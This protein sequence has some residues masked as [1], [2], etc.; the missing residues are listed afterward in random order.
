[1]Q[2][3]STLS[4]GT[5]ARK[6]PGK[7]DLSISHVQK[8][9]GGSHFRN[10]VWVFLALLIDFYRAARPDLYLVPDLDSISQALADLADEL[11]AANAR[12]LS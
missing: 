6:V 4:I 3:V 12:K 8:D 5:T 9:P 11:E 2:I 10:H 1:M 7:P